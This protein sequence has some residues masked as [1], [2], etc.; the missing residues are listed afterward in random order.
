MGTAALVLGIL[1]IVLGFIPVLGIGAA[2]LFGLIGAVLGILGMKKAKQGLATNKGMALAGTILSVLAIVLGIVS[3]LLSVLFV[4]SLNSA[5]EDSKNDPVAGA[6]GSSTDAKPAE[7]GK[8]APAAPRFPGQLEKDVVGDAGNELTVG[9]TAI[10]VSPLTETDGNLGKVFCSDVS[11]KNNGSKA[12][13][14]FGP[15]SFKVQNPAGSATNASLAAVDGELASS[16]LAPGGTASG[17]LCFDAANVSPGE[18]V[19]LYEELMSFD[20]QRGAWISKIG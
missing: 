7:D 6:D 9:E 5:I 11:V 20:Q 15:M 19:V 17:K 13:T 16:D 2:L 8:A 4:G 18:N 3:L 12:L 14:G 10:T 1:G